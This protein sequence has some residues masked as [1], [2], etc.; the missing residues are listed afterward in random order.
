MSNPHVR[1][2]GELFA[3]QANDLL[4]KELAK[5][6]NDLLS[7]CRPACFEL[8]KQSNDKP[9]AE[10][11]NDLLMKSRPAC[12]ELG[13]QANDLL[14]EI[15]AEQANDLLS[16]ICTTEQPNGLLAKI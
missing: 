10:Q 9:F 5:K 8:G 7:E 1:G 6:V 15:F 3:K 13:K 16:E 4:G 11:A 2:L 12:P 14:G